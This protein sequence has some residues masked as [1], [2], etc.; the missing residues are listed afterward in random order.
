MPLKLNRCG[1][2]G[3]K[4]RKKVKLPG[5]LISV[6]AIGI[7]TGFALFSPPH[8]Q[9]AQQPDA[10]KSTAK[11]FKL[12]PS[13]KQNTSTT[14]AAQTLLSPNPSQTTTLP[15]IHKSGTLATNE[16]WTSGNVYVVDGTFEIDSGTLTIEAG[17]IVKLTSTNSYQG[18]VVNGGVVDVL[19][20]ATDP[21]IFTSL[22]DDSV[23]GDSG[24]DGVT[25]G[26]TG[27][28]ATAI[29]FYS[30]AVELNY[31]LIRY[32][33]KSVSTD[34][35][36]SSTPR[37]KV[38]DS[39]I[40]STIALKQSPVGTID[41]Q[42]ND[43]LP[44]SGFA[45]YAQYTTPIGIV[46]DG[47]DM[48]NFGGQGAA[49]TIYLNDIGTIP[50]GETWSINGQSGAVLVTG[51]QLYADGSLDLSHGAILK[52]SLIVNGT[53]NATGS[54]TEPIVFTTSSD[55]SVGGDSDN[56]GV[57]TGSE[58]TFM[59]SLRSVQGSNITVSH[60]VF[61]YS[62]SALI[63]G[64]YSN[65]G[66]SSGSVEITDSMLKSNIS[67]SGCG[68][69]GPLDLERN[70]FDI[71]GIYAI[72]AGGIDPSGIILAGNDK[73]VFSG[74][75]KGKVVYLFNGS[76]G[77]GT[78]DDGKNWTISS[79][80][81]ATLVVQ[82]TIHNQGTIY[83]TAGARIKVNNTL[84]FQNE[85]NGVLDF[86]GTASSPVVITSSRDDSVGG[87][88]DAPDDYTTIARNYTAFQQ[89][90]G[91]LT[92]Q[93]VQIL[94]PETALNMYDGQATL[95]QV[96][97][98]HAIYGFRVMGGNSVVRAS[99]S[100]TSN[101]AAQAC[102][103]YS[104]NCT[105]DASYTDWGNAGPTSSLVCG[106]VTVAPWKNGA[107]VVDGSVYTS[108]NCNGSAA[109][110]DEQLNVSA[111]NYSDRIA[112]K[113]IDCGNGFQ[114]ACQA[115]QT[116]YQCLS[117]AVDLAASTTPFPLPGADPTDAITTW[118][119]DAGAASQVYIKAMEG[120]TPTVQALEFG[121]GLISAL[122]TIVSLSNA[123]NTCAP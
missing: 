14:V 40:Q 92:L 90:A 18:I 73:N 59:A 74:D 31:S 107:S 33:Y 11:L 101:Y 98:D 106:Q 71:N 13:K 15:I 72:Q 37:L 19:G 9:P 116:A 39:D 108:R 86:Q 117:S 2:W 114:D 49:R 68:S 34:F 99:F 62:G 76:G 63:S 42:R 6:L 110:P 112:A 75:V 84:A 24:G 111:Q 55:D 102:N 36:N 82:G 115:M 32:G 12:K 97:V 119:D 29:N 123:Y 44:S 43:M 69:F 5:F 4:L 53:L 122:N 80:G 25:T 22:Q 52:A 65:N 50:S 10:A 104:T 21:A 17:A 89:D 41:M 105:V 87:N 81:G 1:R 83:A 94:Y 120:E 57:S 46:L 27:D 88:T 51:Q 54:S 66:C 8:S 78:V 109:T 56:G 30:G 38:Y 100:D 77:A 95:T 85:S 7:L 118:A 70:T 96:L 67:Y 64:T 79:E 103:W 20:S 45:V 60:A 35:S 61:Q 58:N 121:N 16:T 48:N 91:D 26:S 28:Y 93:N 113:G 23:G 3:M 47:A